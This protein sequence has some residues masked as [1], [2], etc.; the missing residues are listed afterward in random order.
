[1]KYIHI[2]IFLMTTDLTKLKEYWQ[3][4]LMK[5]KP[6]SWLRLFRRYIKG[7]MIRFKYLILWRLANEMFCCG[8]KKQKKC[9]KKINQHL[10]EKYNIEIALGAHIGKQLNLTH[11]SGIVISSYVNIGDNFTIKQNSTIG[12]K[13]LLESHGKSN[14][15]YHITIGKN[16]FLGASSCIIGDNLN[17]G[18]NV[19]I[20]AMSYID[21][22]I[23]GNC[24]I[25]TEKSNKIIYE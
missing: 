15:E 22:N 18:D 7:Y 13:T 23:S 10:I 14:S 6:F 8:S 3:A 4:D 9:A 16:V 24:T 21:K 19:K 11:L 2:I 12:I 1:M 17:I 5:D 25:I 20:G